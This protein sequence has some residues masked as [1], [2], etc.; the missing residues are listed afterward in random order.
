MHTILRFLNHR[1]FVLTLALVLGFVLGERL[2]LLAELSVYSLGVVMVFATSGFSFSN[3][4]PLRKVVA[5]IAWSML[6][7]YLVFGLVVFVL[8]WM[9]L[10]T[11]DYRPFFVGMVLLIAS[12]PGPS[13]V[14]FAT[15]LKGDSNFAITGVFGLHL[16]AML[17]APLILLLVLG[18]TV[19][20]PMGI[21]LIML[22]TIFIPLLVSRVLR[23]RRLITEV[24][25]IK[26]GVIKWGFFLVI[27]PIMGMSSRVLFSEPYPLLVITAIFLFAMFVVGLGYFMV[28]R[29]KGFAQPFLISS[30]LMLTTK[31]SAFAAVVAFSFF[32]DDPRVALP[33]AI[34][35]VLVTLFVVVFS[36]LLRY[37]K[38]KFSKTDD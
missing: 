9:L 32:A 10:D 12:P 31:S 2:K 38:T 19:I 33:A 36:L 18:Q 30:T 13:V 7:N 24:K 35:S 8:G 11:G 37:Q 28:M 23:H 6:L 21:F 15:M 29:T 20:E 3:W 22:K 25:K 1:D 17:I 16:L 26:D 34:V 4:W 14:P 5:P 27:A